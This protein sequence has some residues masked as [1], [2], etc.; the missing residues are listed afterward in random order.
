MVDLMPL[1]SEAFAAGVNCIAP[2]SVHRQVALLRGL[3][4]TH[5]R[6]IAYANVG[7]PCPSDGSKWIDTDAI[8][9]RKYAEYAMQWREAGASIIGGCCGTTPEHIRALA[10]MLKPRKN[11]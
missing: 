4:A 5:V 7:E 2:G 3:L 6:I 1:M 8:D 10:D 11:R 9:P